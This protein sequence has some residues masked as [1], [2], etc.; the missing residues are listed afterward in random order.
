MDSRTTSI[1]L[2]LDLNLDLT[3]GI[4]NQYLS[5]K[6][7]IEESIDEKVRKTKTYNSLKSTIKECYLT[8]SLKYGNNFVM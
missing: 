5:S 2:N 4:A 3:K 8:G 1:L 6:E 7:K